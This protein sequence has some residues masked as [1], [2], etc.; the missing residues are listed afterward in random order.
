MNTAIRVLA[1]LTILSLAACDRAA[2]RAERVAQRLE[3][4]AAKIE[5]KT[6]KVA[7][8]VREEM[9]EGNLRLKSGSLPRAEI[10]P[11]GELLIDGKPLGLDAEQRSLALAYREEM[12]AVAAAGA[13]IGM[14]GAALAV[15]A[16]GET[17][18]ALFS[19]DAE[20]L[21]SRVDDRVQ[22]D[23]GKIRESALALCDRLTALHRAQDAL[24]AAV[25]EFVPY[26]RLEADDIDDCDDEEI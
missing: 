16:L 8:K 11:E 2:D 1:V 12:I 23:A 25:P 18:N 26:A 4:A 19:G 6:S 24:A 13:E 20:N 9:A 5:A 21:Q 7:E 22:D 10:T 14:D 3:A 15:H 17:A